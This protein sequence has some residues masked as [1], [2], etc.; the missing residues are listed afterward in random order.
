VVTGQAPSV[1]AEGFTELIGDIVLTC[2]GGTP[3][4]TGSQ[5]PA[6]DIATITVNLGSIPVTSRIL[7]STTF[8]SEATLLLDEPGSGLAGA[9]TDQVACSPFTTGANNACANSGWF[10][11]TASGGVGEACDSSFTNCPNAF[12]GQIVNTN[13]LVFNNIPILPPATAGDTRV[14]RIT[15]IRVNANA[16]GSV[17]GVAQINANVTSTVGITTNGTT[18]V[19]TVQAGLGSKSGVLSEIGGSTSASKINPL[20]FLQCTSQ[21]LSEP[22]GAEILQYSAGFPSAFKTRGN[23]AT[24]LGST[25]IQNNPVNT[26]TYKANGESGFVSP[27][28]GNAGLADF[29][30]RLRAVFTNIPSGVSVF[31]TTSNVTGGTLASNNITT[32]SLNN[33]GTPGTDVALLMTGELAS[34]FAIVTPTNTVGG[35]NATLFQL[36][37][38]STGTAEAV[39]EVFQAA[40]PG[41]FGNLSFGVFYT[42]TANTTATPFT[43]PAGT[44]QVAISFAPAPVP[45]SA[46]TLPATFTAAAGAAPSST[47]PVPR[48]ADT[49]GNFTFNSITIA[50]CQTVLLYPFVTNEQGFETGLQVAN[51]TNM[52]IGGKATFT[53]Q[54]GSCSVSFFGDATIPDATL[55]FPATA[56]NGNS[57]SSAAMTLSSL[58]GGK[59]F[60]GYAVANC[61][62][63]G[64]H[65]IAFW[66]DTSA[67]TGFGVNPALVVNNN[68][69][70]TRP[71]APA[72]ESLEN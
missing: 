22:N 16:F 52:T 59:P 62:F 46:P 26:A 53:P 27:V 29:G 36:P 5:I 2:S 58:T 1:R 34:E 19:A 56:A 10:S 68:T 60:Q 40:N 25:I 7:N 17:T 67:S 48:F 65:G 20:L 72:A 6:A 70:I 21:S 57:A 45:T 30:T 61:N 50:P 37:V 38:S 64:A 9:P 31:V 42:Y 18:P 8:G 39:W 28:S 12:Q 44:G 69:T 66:T 47:L 33:V 11:G 3:V 55:T 32:A 23:A 13:T 43:P 35:G 41:N 51:T 24:T 15:N 14:L 71:H 54:A 49:T 63:Q 4:P